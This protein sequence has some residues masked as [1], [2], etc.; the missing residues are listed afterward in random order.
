MILL[1][2][3]L[4]AAGL[5]VSPVQV[6]LTPEE[7][8]ALVTI[9]NDG[10]AETRF[11]VTAT[12]WDEDAVKGMVLTPTQD[13]VFFPALFALKA[14]ET[15]NVRVGVTVPFG[16]VERT[17]R[18][19]IE[20]LPPR[21]KPSATSSVRVLTRVGI[22]VFVA[23]LK[24]LNDVKLS[25]IAV[26]PGKVAV[27]VRNAGNEHFRVDAVRLEAM[28]QGGAKMFEKQAPGWYVL[29][30]GHK[31]YEL[32]VP[33]EECSRVRRLIISVK[34]EREEI[35]QQALDTPGGACSGV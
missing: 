27:D 28:A 2:V 14:G 5:N 18:V 26:S 21:E 3:A 35:Y 33:R 24:T 25:A 8:K 10:S 34:T 15:R 23:P 31:K 22:P 9:R 32:E 12:A 11:Q 16:Q 13:V 1:G 17:Y 30:G 20:E 6:R 29:A 4:L 7:S 19:F